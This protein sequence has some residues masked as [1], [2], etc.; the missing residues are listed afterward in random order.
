ME[1]PK[2]KMTLM[3]DLLSQSLFTRLFQGNISIKLLLSMNYVLSIVLS[4]L[5]IAREAYG[6]PRVL[7]KF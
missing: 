3:I 5:G 1:L 4:I 2:E 7:Q 6:R